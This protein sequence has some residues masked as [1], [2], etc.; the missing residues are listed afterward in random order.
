MNYKDLETPSLIVDLDVLD[1]NILHMQNLA[2]ENNLEL[3][4]MIKT[5]K[6]NY[7][8]K[9]Q[10]SAGAKGI[11]VAKI[12]EAEKLLDSGVKEIMLAYPIIGEKKL[13][14]VAELSK[15]VSLY[16]S[17]DSVKSTDIINSLGKSLGKVFNIIILIDSGL[18]RLGIAPEKILQF[19]NDVKDYPYIKIKGIGTHA[20]HVYA[21]RSKEEVIEVSKQEVSSISL[22]A[23]N[24]IKK[25]LELDI[26][27]IG[28]TPTIL[29]AKDFGL[30]KQIR[31]GNYV[32]NDAI[33]LALG[34][35]EKSNCALTVM[36]SVISIRENGEAIID[37]GSKSLC[38]DKGA[39]GN[40][41][42]KGYGMVKGKEDIIITSLSEELGKIKY[43]INKHN[44]ELG[45]ILEIIPNHSCTTTNMFEKAFGFRKGEFIEEIDISARGMK[46]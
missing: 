7:I 17:V 32:F 31:P 16:L 5:H 28:S 23:K 45:D 42:I 25:N 40:D 43:D 26:I 38:L 2:S 3:W 10:I 27:S 19:Y 24:L 44:I 20:G 4:P 22:A 33:Q 15:K 35:R 21:C 46:Y 14:R 9:K 41:N 13:M 34:V 12:S 39:H 29:V 11:L 37:A 18:N 30:V 6:S 8:L 36:T 1:Q